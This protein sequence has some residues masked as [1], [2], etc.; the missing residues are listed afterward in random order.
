MQDV[1][2][3]VATLLVT[4]EEP[5]MVGFESAACTPPPACTMEG[6]EGKTRWAPR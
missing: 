2:T 6:E 1:G 3:S 5:L 4:F